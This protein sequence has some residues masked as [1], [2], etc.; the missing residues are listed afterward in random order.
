MSVYK[1]VIFLLRN[2]DSTNKQVR[3]RIYS[4]ERGRIF[5]I[6]DF[7]DLDSQGSLRIILCELVSEEIILRLARGIYCYPRIVDGTYFIPSDE[8]IAYALAYKEKV[9]IL[10]YGD[11]AAFR[12]GLTGLKIS[13]NRY[14]T[15]G[16][17]RKISLANGRKI[18]FIHTSEVKMFSFGNETMQMISSAIRVLGR[19]MIGAEQMRVLRERIRTVPEDEFKK[20]IVIPPE[21]VQMIMLELWSR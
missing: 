5:F 11:K 6:Q 14:L 15:D 4:W 8:A 3:D 10:P 9:R 21:W 18:Y 13:E 7:S 1:N 19:D 16:A 2:M 17:P 12:L 20:D